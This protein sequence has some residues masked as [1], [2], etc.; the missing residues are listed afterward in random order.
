M[1][2]LYG[3]RSRNVAVENIPSYVARWIEQEGRRA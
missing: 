3:A 1:K 2:F